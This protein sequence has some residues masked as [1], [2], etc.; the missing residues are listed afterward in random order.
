MEKLKLNPNGFVVTTILLGRTGTTYNADPGDRMERWYIND[1]C[2]VMKHFMKE[3]GRILFFCAVVFLLAF[4]VGFAAKHAFIFYSVRGT[5]AGSAAL[6]SGSLIQIFY[7]FGTLLIVIPIVVV[8]VVAVV[9][10]FVWTLTKAFGGAG[11][12]I[13]ALP[14]IKRPE[15]VKLLESKW[16][17]FCV[18]VEFKG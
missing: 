15:L 12:V 2:R 6:F 4:C 1:S 7:L 14:S 11:K 9:A 17:K 16:K 10:G 3:A 8:A 18:P 5:L 13:D